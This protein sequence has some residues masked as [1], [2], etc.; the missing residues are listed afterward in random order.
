MFAG[1]LSP[2]S[3]E[4]NFAVKA[5]SNMAVLGVIA[6][7]GLGFDIVSLGELLK[8]ERAGGDL[9]KVVFSGVGKSR[10]EIEQA[11]ERNILFFGVESE[12][13]LDCMLEVGR[14]HDA[15]VPVALRMNPAVDAGTHPYISTGMRTSKFG[16]PE[17]DIPALA[18][19]I[20]ESEHAELVALSCHIGSQIVDAA[21][22]KAVALAVAEMAARLR[23]EGVRVRFIDLGGGFGIDYSSPQGGIDLEECLGAYLA[24]FPPEEGAPRLMFEPGRTLVA[25]AGALLTRTRYLK[26]AG[27]RTFAV[28]DAA[29]NDLLRPALYSAQHRILPVREP[30]VQDVAV[31]VDVVGPV[32]ESSDFLAKGISL[33]VGE[34]DLLAVQDAGAYGMVMASNYNDRPRPCEV[35]VDGDRMWLARARE[36]YDSMFAPETGLPG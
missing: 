15:C 29:M 25:R 7:C 26:R 6:E 18:R 13:E 4:I 1:T 14:A 17:E 28:V 35:M 30:S 21:A 8:V 5:N 20:A 34:G 16:I 23:D 32:C 12:S 19:R 33:V 22:M 2:L 24:A 27:G 9:S 11:L 10:N 31:D 36:T 3:P